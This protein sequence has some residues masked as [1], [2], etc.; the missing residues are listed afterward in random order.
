MPVKSDYECGHESHQIHR[1]LML[2]SAAGGLMFTSLATGL[3]RAAESSK[4]RPKSVIV[5][6]LQ[7]GP[8]Q[9]DTFDPKPQAPREL[10]GP[11]QPIATATPG[12]PFTEML[13]RLARLTPHFNLIRSLSHADQSHTMMNST[14]S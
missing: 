2:Q 11:Y 7:G 14:R 13:P 4:Q 1:R 6:W 10:R 9:L 12:I 5:L 3:A 8:S